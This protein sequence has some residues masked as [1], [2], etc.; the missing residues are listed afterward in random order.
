MGCGYS[1][2]DLDDRQ[3]YNSSYTPDSHNLIHVGEF[4]GHQFGRYYFDNDREKILIKMN[5]ISRFER[6]LK[7]DGIKIIPLINDNWEYIFINY[8]HLIQQMKKKYHEEL[9]NKIRNEVRLE[10]SENELLLSS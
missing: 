7:I 1:S 5:N 6:I 4:N 8:D 2:A 10:L 9:K 3:Y